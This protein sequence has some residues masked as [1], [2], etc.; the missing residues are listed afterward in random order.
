MPSSTLIAS[1]ASMTSTPSIPMTTL[2]P[3]SDQPK[4]DTPIPVIDLSQI[5]TQG[6]WCLIISCVYFN[7]FFLE[8]KQ[9][10]DLDC[11]E[12]TKLNNQID[13]LKTKVISLQDELV[14]AQKKNHCIS[15]SN[16]RKSKK[17]R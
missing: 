2:K 10:L 3:S 9:K 15:R 5:N 1:S 8:K 12:C 16:R 11:T 7:F 14:A 17:I 13:S 4:N 6:S